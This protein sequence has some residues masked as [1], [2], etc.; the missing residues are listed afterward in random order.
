M[1]CTSD[2]DLFLAQNNKTVLWAIKY[3][4]WLNEQS[5]QIR[6]LSWGDFS[7]ALSLT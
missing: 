4:K 1:R 5:R 7:S 6:N 3:V 2:M